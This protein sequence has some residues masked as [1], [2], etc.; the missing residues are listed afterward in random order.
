M[1]IVGGRGLKTASNAFKISPELTEMRMPVKISMPQHSRI[2]DTVLAEIDLMRGGCKKTPFNS[3]VDA[4]E[5][6]LNPLKVSQI[7]CKT[8]VKVAILSQSRF[9]PLSASFPLYFK[10]FPVFLIA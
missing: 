7:R 5:K 1:M 9:S 8:Q 3:A 10:P 6:V 4:P 2:G